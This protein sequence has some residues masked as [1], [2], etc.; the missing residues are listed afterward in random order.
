MET[1]KVEFLANKE[2]VFAGYINDVK[3]AQKLGEFLLEAY[4]TKIQIT[5]VIIGEKETPVQILGGG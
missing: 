4:G 5:P 3:N 2:W 1:N